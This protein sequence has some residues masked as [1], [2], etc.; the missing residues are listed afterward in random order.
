MYL[1]LLQLFKPLKLLH[2]SSLLIAP[3]LATS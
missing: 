3:T 2:P 1:D